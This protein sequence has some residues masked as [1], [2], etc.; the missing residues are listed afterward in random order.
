MRRFLRLFRRYTAES[1]LA[2]EMR[3][4]FDEKV[5]ELVSCGMPRPLAEA[6]VRRRF[7]NMTALAEQSR[8]EWAYPRVENLLQDLRYALRSLARNPL[9]AAVV[10]VP[11]ALGIGANTAIFSVVE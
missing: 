2:G 7:G 9:F 8:D 6:E 1:Q 10:I 4:H 11:L 3:E 5:D